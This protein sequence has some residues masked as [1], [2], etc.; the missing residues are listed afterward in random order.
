[1]FMSMETVLRLYVSPYDHLTMLTKLWTAHEPIM[2]DWDYLVS[3]AYDKESG[4]EV[5]AV[6]TQYANCI[7]YDADNVLQSTV[8]VYWKIDGDMIDEFHTLQDAKEAYEN[9]ICWMR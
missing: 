2:L 1:M 3:P 8:C 4:N 5:G 9:H 6:V 7:L